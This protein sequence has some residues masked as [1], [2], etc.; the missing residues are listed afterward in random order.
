MLMETVTDDNLRSIAETLG[1]HPSV[2]QVVLFGSRAR[3]N[4]SEHSDV[5]LLVICEGRPDKADTALRLRELLPRHRFGIDLLVMG[6]QQFREEKDIIGTIAFP[7][8]KYGRV[9][10]ERPLVH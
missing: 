3:S 1:A 8:N 4:A 10:H 6:E 7:A 5:D 9:L 2:L